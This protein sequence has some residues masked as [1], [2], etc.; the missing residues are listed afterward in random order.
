M[1]RGIRVQV[2]DAHTLF[3]AKHDQVLSV[4][5]LGGFF[6]EYTAFMV[7]NTAHVFIPPRRVYDV[8]V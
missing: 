6:A 4:F 1:T 5:I 2:Q 8:Q 3:G 7:V